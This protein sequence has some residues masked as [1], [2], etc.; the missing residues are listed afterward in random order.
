MSLDKLIQN[1]RNW[2]TSRSESDPGFFPRLAS[3]QAPEFLW[4]GCSDSRVP[5]NEIVGL[6]PGELFV[7][8]NVANLV[9]H[10]DLNCLSVLHFAV[11][12]LKVRHIMV[13]GHYGCAGIKSAWSTEPL[14]LVDSWLRHVEDVAAQH[15]E[16]LD[17]LNDDQL[18]LDR[19]SEFNVLHQVVNVCRTT[20]V[21]EAWAAGQDITVHGL[22]YGI[23]DGL[24]SDLQISCKAD[25]DLQSAYRDSAARRMALG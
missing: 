23:R 19:L 3:Q 8:R 2:A 24:L 6:D 5:A 17:S 18:L 21:Q 11:K 4:I 12:I 14:G 25:T 15:K 20:V 10:S 9:V 13:V 22:V 16:A 7:H 1:N